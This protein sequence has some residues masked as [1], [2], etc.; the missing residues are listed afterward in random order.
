MGNLS[1]SNCF[2]C[3][4]QF[5]NLLY[6]TKLIFQKIRTV[7]TSPEN[8]DFFIHW[9]Y[10]ILDRLTNKQE[11]EGIKRNEHTTVIL[12]H[13]NELHPVSPNPRWN[14]LNKT[15]Q[16]HLHNHCSWTLQETWHTCW[17]T[18][19]QHIHSSRNPIK[20]SLQ[21]HFYKKWNMKRIHLIEDAKICLR[22]V[23][24]IAQTVATP[25]TKP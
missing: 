2:I 4:Y 17:K 1:Q 20:K 13:S 19:F 10:S 25:L 14:P 8:T 9:T 15:Y 18:L 23:E 5:I 6:R 3:N 16:T 22:L 12:V 7:W 11:S 21:S 24:Q